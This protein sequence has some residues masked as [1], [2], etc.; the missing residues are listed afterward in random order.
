MTSYLHSVARHALELE[1]VVSARVTGWFEPSAAERPDG[2]SSLLA[3]SEHVSKE[4]AA[5]SSR[6]APEVARDLF[7][8][9]PDGPR[10]RIAS[11][12]RATTTETTTMPAVVARAKDGAESASPPARADRDARA[13]QNV[14]L[15]SPRQLAAAPRPASPVLPR[16]DSSE[17]VGRTPAFETV[18][19]IGLDAREPASRPSTPEIALARRAAPLATQSLLEG[20]S[21]RGGAPPLRPEP[22]DGAASVG[23]NSP[24]RPLPALVE[25]AG[26]RVRS[27]R[28]HVD[29]TPL[30]LQPARYREARTQLGTERVATQS[31][32]IT[33]GR[34]E[35]RATAGTPAAPK[36]MAPPPR[37]AN[38]LESYLNERNRGRA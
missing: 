28:P 27:N 29:A 24:E 17:R 16:A 8:R 20:E 38:T 18:R 30:Q 25:K 4:P 7:E 14:E 1:P 26:R 5:S 9:A 6:P 12:E 21:G 15:A 11:A 23:S 34:I 32:N 33:I 36:P 19:S 37:R 22:A 10:P 2:V 31:V 3:T 35:V 13:G